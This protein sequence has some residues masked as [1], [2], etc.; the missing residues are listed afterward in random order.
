MRTLRGTVADL[1][2]RVHRISP[3]LAATHTRQMPASEVKQRFLWY[4][5]NLTTTGAELS[6]SDPNVAPRSGNVSSTRF[7]R[8]E[9][10]TAGSRHSTPFPGDGKRLPD[11]ETKN[12]ESLR[13]SVELASGERLDHPRGVGFAVASR[14]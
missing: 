1:M 12:R 10:M 11:S 8:P 6:A 14:V 4:V 5:R 7:S 3:E 2:V 9:T 13:A